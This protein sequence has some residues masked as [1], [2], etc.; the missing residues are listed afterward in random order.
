MLTYLGQAL[1]LLS[2]SRRDDAYCYV[3]IPGRCA[4]RHSL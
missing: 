2:A 1:Y 4:L 3:S